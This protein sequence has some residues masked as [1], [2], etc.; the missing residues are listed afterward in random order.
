MTRSLLPLAAALALAP[1]AASAGEVQIPVAGPLVELTV[2][3]AVGGTP[4]LAHLS[5]TVTTLNLS[6]AES[7]RE[8]AERMARVIAA[9]EAQGVAKA[10]IQTSEIS[11]NPRYT[12]ESNA[13]P[14]VFRGYEVSSTV[15]IKL[16]ELPRTGRVLD[17]MA[18]AGAT[19]LGEISWS[20]EDPSA[21]RQEAREAAFDTARGRAQGF[22]RQ[23]GYADVRLLEVSESSFASDFGGSSGNAALS[24]ANLTMPIRPGEVQTS[25][26]ISVKYEMVR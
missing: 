12:Y 14:Q 9:V 25:V 4:D 13:R 20:V 10:D 11:L 16:R 24:A 23:A 21:A 19:E 26:T 3:E 5:A 17:A 2:T 15:K 18:T 7:L 1:V 8:N 22:A 6:A